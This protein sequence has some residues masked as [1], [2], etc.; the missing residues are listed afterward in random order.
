MSNNSQSKSTSLSIPQSIAT[1][2]KITGNTPVAKMLMQMDIESFNSLRN[3]YAPKTTMQEFQLYLTI[4]SQR[5]LN[6][7]AA[8]VNLI[9]RG[10]DTSRKTTIQVTIDGL[11]AIATR[12]GKFAGSDEPEWGPMIEA[13]TSKYINDVR[14]PEWCK[15]TT[16]TFSQGV[17]I[18]HPMK[19]FWDE[20]V[21]VEKD[22]ANDKP[23]GKLKIGKMYAQM[24]RHMLAKC[25]EA[26]SL[27]KGS[28]ECSGLYIHEEMMQADA[29]DNTLNDIANGSPI[30]DADTTPEKANFSKEEPDKAILY[31]AQKIKEFLASLSYPVT[32]NAVKEYLKTHQLST[33]KQ[34]ENFQYD[35]INYNHPLLD[36]II[37]QMGIETDGAFNNSE[38]DKCLEVYGVTS[39]NVRQEIELLLENAQRFIHHVTD[40]IPVPVA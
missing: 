21:P 31:I 4:C 40:E 18:A 13:D 6:P 30:V 34:W 22:Y 9:V 1:I 2:P 36:L 23:T 24:P 17:K 19:L 3:A 16:Y 10:I 15:V 38:Y 29:R 26:A 7:F 32:P 35:V 27:R 11:R 37:I 5:D 39:E 12:S 14:H 28:P 20:F 33:I 25:A 8:Q